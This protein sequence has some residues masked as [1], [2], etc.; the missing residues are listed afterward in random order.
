MKNSSSESE[1]PNIEYFLD[2]TTDTCPMTFVRTK[3]LLEQMR[4]GELAEIRLMGKEPTENVPRSVA[5]QGHAVLSMDPE[6]SVESPGAVYRLII[7]K[8]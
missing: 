3:L 8:G 2:I 5:Q 4:S 6:Q 1:N 7:K